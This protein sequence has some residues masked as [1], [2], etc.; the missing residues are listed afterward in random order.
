[1]KGNHYTSRTAGFVALNQGSIRNCYAD[2]KVKN[3]ANVAGFV[4]ESGGSIVQCLAQGKTV[5]KENVACFCG[6]NR[7]KLDAA[8]YLYAISRSDE[9]KTADQIKA[10]QRYSDRQLCLLYT[11]LGERIRSLGFDHTWLVSNGRVERNRASCMHVVEPTEDEIV[12]VSSAQQLIDLAGAIASG[13]E[14]AASTHYRLTCDIDFK[15]AR[16]TPIGISESM[17]FKGTFDGAGHKIHNFKVVG[18]D[19]EAAGLF[20]YIKNGVVANLDVDCV[21]NAKGSMFSGA[22][23]GVNGGTIVNCAVV[24]KIGANKNCGGFCGKNYGEIVDCSFVGA[25]TPAV[26]FWVYLLPAIIAALILLLVGLM[27]LIGRMNETPYQPPVIDPGSAP[28]VEKDPVVKPSGGTSL[29][30]L[31]LNRDVYVNVVPDPTSGR[32]AGVID[33]HNPARSTETIVLR[34]LISDAELIAHGFT[35]AGMSAEDYAARAAEPG[36]DAATAYQEMFRSGLIPIGY[37]LQMIGLSP[38][39]NGS[40][41]PEGEYA[42]KAV[43]DPY[44]PETHEKSIVNAEAPINVYIVK[45]AE[46]E[47]NEGNE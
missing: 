2:A 24:A 20:G 42:M 17:P 16:L 33:C 27:L 45:S 32:Q 12:E 15:G 8:G 19:L 10:L 13:D 7:G 38:L 30:S 40:Y 9:G 43:L 6:T 18:K 3:R 21:V 41:L 26:P 11:D 29:I 5:G 14:N 22:L 35:Y 31:N 28:V 23:C 36:Y 47:S 34:I 25:V 46:P 1:M 44:D 4:C 37:N 39:Q